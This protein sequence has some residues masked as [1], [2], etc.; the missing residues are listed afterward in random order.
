M[1]EIINCEKTKLKWYRHHDGGHILETSSPL[2]TINHLWSIDCKR[3]H[4]MHLVQTT[5]SPNLHPYFFSVWL[6]ICLV[7]LLSLC[8]FEL[9]DLLF[10]SS[11][12]IV[13]SDYL[14]HDCFSIFR[15]WNLIKWIWW[16]YQKI[17]LK[18]VLSLIRIQLKV[19]L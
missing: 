11:L 14:S 13:V 16:K 10:F 19:K 17:N 2:E 4:T 15:P 5:L 3:A 9:M 1:R 7:S 18:C 8:N 12:Q 6:F